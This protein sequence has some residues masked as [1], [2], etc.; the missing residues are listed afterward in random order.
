VGWQSKEM[1]MWMWMV[2]SRVPRADALV[3]PGRRAL[4]VVDA[5]LWPALALLLMTQLDVSTGVVGKAAF[6]GLVIALAHRAY[7]AVLMNGRY[8]F[9]TARLATVLFWAVAFDGLLAVV[10]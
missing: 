1:V 3:W 4:G 7:T 8:R 2:F 10:D 6:S 9:T 5:L